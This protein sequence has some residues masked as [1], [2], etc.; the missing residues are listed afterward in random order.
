MVLTHTHLGEVFR[1]WISMLSCTEYCLAAVYQVPS[2]L[3]TSCLTWLQA[4]NEGRGDH[5]LQRANDIALIHMIDMTF[6]YFPH[7]FTQGGS[8]NRHASHRLVW[9]LL[10]FYLH[11]LMVYF[12]F[13]F[14]NGISIYHDF[15]PSLDHWYVIFLFSIAHMGHRKFPAHLVDS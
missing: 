12:V 7:I 13:Y 9:K 1:H 15:L 4:G 6:Q 2:E 8:G 3:K 11:T 14:I 10:Q 5:G